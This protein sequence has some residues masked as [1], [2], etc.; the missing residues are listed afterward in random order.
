MKVIIV[1]FGHKKYVV[2]IFICS[3]DNEFVMD[4]LLSRGSLEIGLSLECCVV[5]MRRILESIRDF[6]KVIKLYSVLTS[7][8]FVAHILAYT[9]T[10]SIKI[11]C[12]IFCSCGGVHSIKN[13]MQEFR[14]K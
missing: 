8:S 14:V 4:V 12:Y 11:R 1:S 7:F 3:N 6:T 10:A 5:R 9:S 2:R 13:R